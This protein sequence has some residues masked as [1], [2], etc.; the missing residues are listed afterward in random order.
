[1]PAQWREAEEERAAIVEYHGG[2]RRT[3]AEGFAR[4]HPDH[5][6]GGVP[7][8]RWRRFIDDVGI[9]LDDGRLT[10]PRSA[11]GRSTCSAATATGRSLGSTKPGFCGY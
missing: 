1:M 6:P 10:P 5:P 8:K 4:L 7:L 2:I 11:G 9:F 3:W